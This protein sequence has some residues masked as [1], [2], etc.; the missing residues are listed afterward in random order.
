[1]TLLSAMNV[2]LTIYVGQDDAHGLD[3]QHITFS[4]RSCRYVAGLQ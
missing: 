2:Y 4:A 3:Q 1:M